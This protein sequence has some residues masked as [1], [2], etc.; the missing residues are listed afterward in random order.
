MQGIPYT[1][2]DYCS[3]D[4][5]EPGQ[6]FWYRKRTIIFTNR[7]ETLATPWKL[8]DG[9]CNGIKANEPGQHS[10]A[11]GFGGR[12]RG[13]VKMI[14]SNISTNLKHRIPQK[15]MDYLLLD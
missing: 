1:V 6:R 12:R 15:L 3:F 5:D 4:S 7:K 9:N 13:N 8:C 11:V 14:V 2:Q 10:H